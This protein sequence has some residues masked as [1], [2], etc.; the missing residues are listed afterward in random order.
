[1]AVAM[2]RMNRAEATALYARR[3][4]MVLSQGGIATACSLVPVLNLLAP[5]LGTACMVHVLHEAVTPPPGL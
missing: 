1:V 3:R 2:R 4:W 5:V